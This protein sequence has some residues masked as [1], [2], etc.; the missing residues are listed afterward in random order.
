VRFS[1]GLT[2][3]YLDGWTFRFEDNGILVIS[4]V[5]NRFHYA[6][7]AWTCVEQ[8]VDRKPGGNWKPTDHRRVSG[9]APD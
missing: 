2:T 9:P 7:H 4:D 3:D 8:D 5:A 1:D 6:P